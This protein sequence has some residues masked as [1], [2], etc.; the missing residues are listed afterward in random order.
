MQHRCWHEWFTGSRSV[1]R[2]NTH[3]T[4]LRD[5][6]SRNYSLRR[7]LTINVTVFIRVVSCLP[8]LRNNAELFELLAA[9]L[10]FVVC[11]RRWR[12]VNVYFAHRVAIHTYIDTHTC[13]RARARTHTL[14]FVRV[15]N[16][17]LHSLLCF[18]V[19]V[20]HVPV[21]CGLIQL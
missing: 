11:F 1:C 5:G 15:F 12:N 18:T 13:A 9:A 21:P 14:L 17:I 20:S 2:S 8:Q 16:T 7:V 3:N 19:R 4:I 6:S 10:H